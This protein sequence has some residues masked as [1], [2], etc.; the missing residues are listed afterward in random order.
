MPSNYDDADLTSHVRS[1][2]VMLSSM[3]NGQQ[4]HVSALECNR[5][6]EKLTLLTHISAL[7]TTGNDNAPLAHSVHAVYERLTPAA[8]ECLVCS[9]NVPQT[10]QETN[11]TQAAPAL[12]DPGRLTSIP[13]ARDAIR[14]S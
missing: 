1:D 14:G 2:I 6:D 10:E 8:L 7:L 9:E 4:A 11:G 12:P 13:D 5:N 3:L